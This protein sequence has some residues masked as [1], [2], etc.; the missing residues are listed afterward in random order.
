MNAS[1][2]HELVKVFEDMYYWNLTHSDGQRQ[3]TRY[4]QR[5]LHEFGISDDQLRD[6]MNSGEA[7]A[8]ERYLRDFPTDAEASG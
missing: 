2:E 3:R 1:L 7:R 5:V 8:S 4:V 6:L